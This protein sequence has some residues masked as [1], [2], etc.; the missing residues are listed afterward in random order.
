MRQVKFVH[1]PQDFDPMARNQDKY[2]TTT[3]FINKA[4]FLL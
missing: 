3:V 2:E 4:M 1:R